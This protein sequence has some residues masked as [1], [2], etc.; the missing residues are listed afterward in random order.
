MASPPVVVDVRK[1]SVV[2]VDK[3]GVLFVLLVLMALAAGRPATA[4]GSGDHAPAL[5]R[6]QRGHLLTHG[7]TQYE[8]NQRTDFG[9]TFEISPTICW[10]SQ[11][12]QVLRR[13]VTCDALG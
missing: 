4:H 12:A 13:R 7:T 10:C 5:Y 9:A 6:S 8:S 3:V 2:G 11:G 1:G